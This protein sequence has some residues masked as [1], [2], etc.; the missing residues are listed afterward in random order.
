VD[1]KQHSEAIRKNVEGGF[2][3]IISHFATSNGSDSETT[4]KINVA[5]ECWKSRKHDLAV[6][7][8]LDALIELYEERA[9]RTSGNILRRQT[10]LATIEMLAA[11]LT[12]AREARAKEIGVEHLLMAMRPGSESAPASALSGPI[13]VGLGL[14][15]DASAFLETWRILDN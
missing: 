14:S 2:Q 1:M 4:A 3:G 8:L 15:S 11:A 6:S 12:F 13:S 10:S 7:L 5:F 9:S